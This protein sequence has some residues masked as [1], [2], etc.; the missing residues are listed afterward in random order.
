MGSGGAVEARKWKEAEDTGLRLVDIR[1]RMRDAKQTEILSSIANLA[2]TYMNL[3][4]Y[5]QAEHLEEVLLGRF[6]SAF[7][8]DHQKTPTSMSNLASTYRD[9]GKLKKAEE[10]ELHVTKKGNHGMDLSTPVG[11]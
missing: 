3:G 9:R 2:S 4:R 5:A 11:P 1:S 7:G 10:L 8:P 6:E